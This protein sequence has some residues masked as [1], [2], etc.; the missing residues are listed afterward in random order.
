MLTH[1]PVICNI[2]GSKINNDLI[3]KFRDKVNSNSYFVLHKYGNV[4]NKN[5]WNIIC[6]CMDWISVAIESLNDLKKDDSNIDIQSMQIF[7]YISSIDIIVEAV[8]QLHRVIINR[9]SVPFKGEKSIF[10]DNTSNKDDNH[11]FKHIRAVFGAHPVNIIDEKGQWFA[12]WPYSSHIEGYDFQVT[13]YSNMIDQDDITFGIKFNELE[14]FLHQRYSYLNTL[15]KTID[16]QYDDYITS[17][18]SLP[19]IK[20]QD[21]IKQ[22]QILHVEAKDRLNSDYYIHAII[23]LFKLF[24]TQI[25][26]NNDIELEYKEKLYTVVDEIYHNLQEMKITDLLTD[27]VLYP[28]YPSSLSYEISKLLSFLSLPTNNHLFDYYIKRIN[29]KSNKQIII[30]SNDSNDLIFLKVKIMMFYEMWI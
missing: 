8:Q 20:N 13:L 12:S 19:I 27:K 21:V 26:P 16:N 6:S 11:Y 5:Q 30:D 23:D 4:E 22:L 25:S 14:E 10:L 24:K 1:A 29:A 17:K 9:T 3:T 15:I 28:N 7:S 18:I 2:K